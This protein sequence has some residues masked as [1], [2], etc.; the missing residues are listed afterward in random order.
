M[1]YIG[2]AFSCQMIPKGMGA[3]VYK[4]GFQTARDML[5]A[6]EH[7]DDGDIFKV[8]L[9]PNVISIIGHDDMANVVS[10]LLD[11]GINANRVSVTL[12]P[13]D[14]LIVAQYTGPRLQEG[15]ISLPGGATIMWYLVNVVY[16]YINTG[17]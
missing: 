14:K 17:D 4:I 2:N 12:E 11:V 10:G 6:Y 3:I 16:D 15:A 7:S 5:L 13:G 9:K 8:G 1:L